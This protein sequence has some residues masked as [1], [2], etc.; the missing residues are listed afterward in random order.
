MEDI[1]SS[2]GI[3]FTILKLHLLSTHSVI[4]GP[5]A[6][7]GYLTQETRDPGFVPSDMDIFIP[8]G[9]WSYDKSD[10]MTIVDF[11]VKA[12]FIV[13]YQ[14]SDNESLAKYVDTIICL[15]KGD[16]EINLLTVK[17]KDVIELI[18]QEFDLSVCVSWWDSKTERFNTLN[19][20]LTK[21]K[22]MYKL[23]NV[24]DSDDVVQ[25]Y[26]CRGFKLV[27]SPCPIISTRDAREEL[28]SEKFT[29]IEVSDILTLEDM[30]LKDFL[31]ASEWNIVIK[32]GERYYA[33]DR[34]TLSNYM[35]T[36]RVYINEQLRVVYETPLNQC[37]S[38]NGLYSLSY[39][40]YTIFKLIYNRTVLT[41]QGTKSLFHVYCYSVKQ[42][43][44]EDK[45]VV[46]H[47]FPKEIPLSDVAIVH[48]REVDRRL[49]YGIDASPF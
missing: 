27:E 36:K 14:I 25:R 47:S 43:I 20:L 4:V 10:L 21:R 19:P 39:A 11:L 46:H 3:N 16:K 41:K 9:L 44:E 48:A 35:K 22:E 42:W 13:K 28:T 23:H 30:P 6:L 38:H 7:A 31:N 5:T 40:D 33:F 34:R 32:A 49:R 8:R 45:M 24:L 18:T 26:I 12:G 15:T 37:I 29:G 1:I 2:Y 17:C